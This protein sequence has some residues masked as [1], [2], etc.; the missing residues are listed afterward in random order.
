MVGGRIAW[1]PWVAVLGIAGTRAP[2]TVADRFGQMCRISTRA[3]HRGGGVHRIVRTGAAGRRPDTGH[4]RLG[5]ECPRR[6]P[7]KVLTGTFC[8]V[9]QLVVS[10]GPGGLASCAGGQ[11]MIAPKTGSAAVVISSRQHVL[12]DLACEQQ[13]VMIDESL[14]AGPGE[15]PRRAAAGATRISRCE[16]LVGPGRHPG[17]QARG[18]PHV[19]QDVAAG[20]THFE[21]VHAQRNGDLLRGHLV[22]VQQ[23]RRIRVA[24]IDDTAHLDDQARRQPARQH[25][26]HP[27]H[28]RHHLTAPGCEQRVIGAHLHRWA[29]Q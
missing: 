21:P 20:T 11:D 28:V 3:T 4:Q 9:P 23:D 27:C 19:E 12:H 22:T 6:T 26:S 14:Q 13:A 25:G 29:P 8:R 24:E 5:H 18:R 17:G 1:D 15:K 2:G 16:E 10:E 7:I